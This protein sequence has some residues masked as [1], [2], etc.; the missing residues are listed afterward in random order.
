MDLGI[1]LFLALACFAVYASVLDNGFVDFDDPQ[2]IVDNLHVKLGLSA[3]SVRWAFSHAYSDNWHPL[4]WLSH[5]LDVELFGLEPA[6]HHAVGVALHTASA[7]VLFVFL[8]RLTRARWPSALAAALFA[9]H[10]LRVESVVWAAERKDVLSGLFF[11]LTLLSYSSYVRRPGAGR[12][13]VVVVC[14]TLGLLSKPMLVT[15]PALLLL[16]DRWPLQRTDRLVPPRNL[17]TEKI[18]LVVLSCAS[19]V[20]TVWAQSRGSTIKS[21]EFISALDRLQNAAISY[22]VYLQQFVWPTDLAFFYPHPALVVRNAFLPIPATAALCAIATALITVAAVRR[23]AERPY[24]TVG[25]L[26][27]LIALAP[28]IGIVQVGAQAHADRYTYL[29]SIGLVIAVAFGLHELVTWLVARNSARTQPIHVAA[30]AAAV[31]TLV[32][33]SLQSYRQVGVWSSSERLYRH[34]LE[35]TQSNYIAAFNLG[36]LEGSRGSHERAIAYYTIAL[37][38]RPQYAAAHSNTGVALEALGK[39][40]EALDHFREALRLDPQLA[41]T[42]INLGNHFAQADDFTT[43]RKHYQAAIDARPDLALPRMVLAELEQNAG[44]LAAAERQLEAARSIEPGS[45]QIHTK[46]GTTLE[47]QGREASAIEHYQRALDIAPEFL[48]AANSLAW[49][50]ATA[51]DAA[52]RDG[53]EALHWAQQCNRA[54]R[55]MNPTF[56]KTLSAAHTQAGDPERAQHFAMRALELTPAAQ[57]SAMREDLRRLQAGRPASR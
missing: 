2:Y 3:E 5:M 53:R 33:L 25:W 30:T 35:A 49:L 40:E 15:L 21:F 7:A 16:L 11:L 52:L 13:T 46:L 8:L 47:L 45:S 57:R 4:T 26:W 37:Q 56:L 20:V 42:A 18:P 19:S 17:V 27:Y 28:V 24:L 1:G 31:A 23:S 22:C 32:T 38:M 14:F 54:T 6:A 12:Y 39:G 9:L 41:Q 50:L 34:A 55:F 51:D 43:A 44:N 29:P 48:P 36:A 10:P